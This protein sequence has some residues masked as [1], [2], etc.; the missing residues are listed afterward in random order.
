MKQLL[1]VQNLVKQYPNGEGVD[2]IGFSIK[3]GEIVGFLG[4]NGA[5]KTTTLRCIAGLYKTQHGSIHIDGHGIEEN[6]VRGMVSFIPDSPSLYPMLTVAEHLQFKAKAFRVSK[7]E[8]KDK[9]MYALQEVNLE[10]Y[11]DRP[12]GHLSRGQKQRVMLAAA[13]IQEADLYLFDEPT[14]GLDIPS[15][16]W[17][18]EWLKKNS[19][20]N[21]GIIIS[22]HSLEFVMETAQR[23]I[24]IKK[25]KL[26]SE[27]GIPIDESEKG[28][29]RQEVIKELGGSQEHD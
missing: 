16:E 28:A 6:Q 4:A 27:K 5:G 10:Q 29:W 12:A 14:V 20:R 22:S 15:K 3:R 1:H 26:I 23:I 9:V 25:G 13:I 2:D 18:A 7:H 11:A 24:L 17:L 21:K 8:L 19:D